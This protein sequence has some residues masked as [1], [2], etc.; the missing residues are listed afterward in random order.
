[1]IGKISSQPA[2]EYVQIERSIKEPGPQI[3]EDPV[4]ER[5]SRESS[6]ET[7]NARKNEMAI[8]GATQKAFLDSQIQLPVKQTAVAA[9]Q[10]EPIADSASNQTLKLGDKGPEVDKLVSDLREW[11]R[12]IGLEEKPSEYTGVY[13]KEIEQAV[14]EFQTASGLPQTGKADPNTQRRLKLEKDPH[15]RALD[16]DVKQT[17]RNSMNIY[18]NQPEAQDNILTLATDRQFTH[19]LSK[20]SQMGALNGLMM[21]PEDKNHLKNVQDEVVNVAILEKEKTLDHLPE[22]TKRQVISTLFK[23]TE[24]TPWF[25]YNSSEARKQV[26]EL[27][28]SPAFAG[29]SESQQRKMMDAV[30]ANPAQASAYMYEI[31]NSNAFKSMDTKMKERVIDLA[32][33]NA[34]YPAITGT[35]DFNECSYRLDKFDE[36]LRNPKFQASSDDDKWAQLNAYRT[37]LSNQKKEI[38]IL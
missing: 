19:L 5:P 22:S 16:N 3:K 6:A 13:T 2:T 35:K 11:Q 21:H 38:D 27:A 1:M 23:K 14:K 36:L 9:K 8:T 15:F 4:Y 30:A 28:K 32:C 25:W 18:A 10:P 31:I 12:R 34:T 33:D 17:I 26:T 7:A 20:D 24:D 29:L 37:P